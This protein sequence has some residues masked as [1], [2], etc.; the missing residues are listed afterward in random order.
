M[1]LTLFRFFYPQLS[2]QRSFNGQQKIVKT[3]TILIFSHLYH[4]LIYIKPAS[5]GQIDVMGIALQSFFYVDTLII[6]MSE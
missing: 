2:Y 6:I 3:K 1:Y 5:R 4:S